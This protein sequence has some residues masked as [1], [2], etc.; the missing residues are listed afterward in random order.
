[1][2]TDHD[3]L[4][5]PPWTRS[6]W[7]V[8]SAVLV[9]LFQVVGSTAAARQQQD[10][11]VP[12][13]AAGYALLLLGPVLLLF[14]NRFPGPVVVGVT[15]VTTGYLLAGYPYGPVFF[16]LAVAVYGA[17]SRGCRRVAWISVGAGYLV[18]LMS[19]HLLPQSW[20]RA[21]SQS[22]GWW[23][24]AGVAAWLLLVLAVAEIMRSRGEQLA[25]RRLARRQA[26][27]NRAAEERLRMARELH[28]ILA[29][30]I[31]VIHL[32][33]GVALEL[34]DEHPD[35]VRA[36]L[37]VIKATSKEALGEV[38][39][40]LGTLRGPDGQA[41]RTPAPGLAR[42][43]ELVTQAGHAGLTVSVETAGEGR[44]L[45]SQLE[46]AAFR[47]V[48]EALTNIIRH[49]AARSA[50]VLMDWTSPAGLLLQVDDPGPAAG[51]DGG[52]SGN[53]L[54][55]MRERAAAFAGELTAGPYGGGFRVRAWLP[56]PAGKDRAGDDRAG[57]GTAGNGAAGG[58]AA[59]NGTA[60][61]RQSEGRRTT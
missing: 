46:L 40:V 20:L 37:T 41:P 13:D 34:I 43:P 32:Q 36:A 28:D 3:P 12:L 35:Q 61:G 2:S 29:H 49:S 1:M 27:E 5:G 24:E 55:G 31:S 60:G 58:G 59:G 51:G 48:Q 9:A 45:P 23:Q 18:H 56:D 25:A 42:L 8:V 38:R 21:P 4:G 14:R 19:S 57:G 16:S 10:Y 44:P 22:P 50:T 47:I 26:E 33:A 6:S 17:L 39:Q 54:V 52:G 15:A 11:R 7:T 30:S 53:G